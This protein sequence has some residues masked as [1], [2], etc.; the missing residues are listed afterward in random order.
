[1]H[2]VGLALSSQ[3]NTENFL[4]IDKVSF[5]WF[6]LNSYFMG[7]TYPKLVCLYFV[8][9]TQKLIGIK[10]RKI[11]ILAEKYKLLVQNRLKLKTFKFSVLKEWTSTVYKN[12][13]KLLG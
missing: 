9:F 10:D 12:E 13:V 11:S 6:F 1:M 8:A 7:K 4:N 5:F 2:T 3:G